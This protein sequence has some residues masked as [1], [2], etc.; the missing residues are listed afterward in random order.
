MKK[1]IIILGIFLV[2]PSA[3]IAKA[4]TKMLMD[5]DKNFGNKEKGIREVQS[6]NLFNTEQHLEYGS[7]FGDNYPIVKQPKGSLNRQ[8]AAEVEGHI[9]KF[10]GRVEELPSDFRLCAGSDRAPRLSPGPGVRRNLRRGPEQL[11][12][13]LT[14]R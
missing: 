10:F 5:V 11:G 12:R 2:L 8:A 3:A 13:K 1:I 7:L 14:G 4:S 6:D 9:R